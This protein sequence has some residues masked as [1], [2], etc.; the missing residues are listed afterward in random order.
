MVVVSLTRVN[1]LPIP[2]ARQNCWKC[3]YIIVCL[4][5][6]LFPLICIIGS[7]YFFLFAQL[8]NA[9]NQNI[10][11][12]FI[13]SKRNL[14]ELD[15]TYFYEKGRYWIFYHCINYYNTNSLIYLA[16]LRYEK[17]L[18]QAR[19]ETK[20]CEEPGYTRGHIYLHMYYLIDTIWQLDFSNISRSGIAEWHS[21]SK[22][23]YNS[24]HTGHW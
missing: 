15:T 20:S 5:Y 23:S 17:H 4:F 2:W 19:K 13:S 10:S 21:L 9:G 22:K 8:K 14:K 18:S 1:S 24:N 12:W 16:M 3:T 7:G 11:F 6:I